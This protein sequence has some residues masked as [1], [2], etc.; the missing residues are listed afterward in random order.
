MEGKGKVYVRELKQDDKSDDMRTNM[1]IGL[2]SDKSNWKT[3]IDPHVVCWPDGEVIDAQMTKGDAES[4]AA[5][6]NAIFQEP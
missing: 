1:R 2:F 5:Q 6:F 3:D 4:V